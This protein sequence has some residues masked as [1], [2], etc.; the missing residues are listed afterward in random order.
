MKPDRSPRLAFV[1]SPYWDRATP[2]TQ[3]AV[4]TFVEAL[5]DI[6][7]PI[8]LPPAFGAAADIHRTLMHAGIAEAYRD[9]Y[10][11]AKDLM[12]GVV[13]GIIES[14]RTLSAVDF[15]AALTARDRA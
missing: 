3:A 13:T 4:E 8:E 9:D 5:G 12:S 1:K 2:S 10:E 14:G 15:I 7:E 11:R 6:V